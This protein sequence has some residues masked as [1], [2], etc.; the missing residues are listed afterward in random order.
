MIDHSRDED[1]SADDDE[2]SQRSYLRWLRL[3]FLKRY[4]RRGRKLKAEKA[5]EAKRHNE[6]TSTV[7]R[8]S[9]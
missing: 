6:Q 4:A 2:A 8:S 1:V 3:R 7:D 5:D 9:C